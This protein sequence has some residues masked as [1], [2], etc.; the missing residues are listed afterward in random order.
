MSVSATTER[1][2]VSP[3]WATVRK[4][5]TRKVAIAASGF[6]LLI[7]FVSVKA[8]WLAPY[9]Y[10]AQHLD[11]QFGA[12]GVRHVFGTDSKGRDLFSRVLY[13]GRISL[14][15]ALAGTAVSVLIGVSWG[16]VAG[17]AGGRVEWVMMRFVDILYSLP[18]TLLVILLIAVCDQSGFKHRFDGLFGF[19][20]LKAWWARQPF[21]L[22]FLF[23]ALGLVQWLTMAR[24]VRARVTALKFGPSIESA[25]AL[26]AGH[27]W[28]MWRH[29]LPHTIPVVIACATL[30]VPSVMLQE[31][32]ISFLGLG[33]QPPAA[34][35]GTLVAEGVK[36]VN[37]IK[38]AWWVILFPSAVLT[39]SLLAF[40]LLGD[41]F[42]DVW[43]R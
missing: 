27:A 21:N 9:S 18:Y 19:L 42:Q 11:Q 35:W 15:I 33:V 3:A 32:F 43:G 30:T 13:G 8:D 4:L 5:F 14:A 28:I 23:V 37:P 7:L 39:A 24:V 29:I 16:L 20:G 10:S 40:N 22:I 36:T 6:I 2:P 34:S 38:M 26:G 17:Y 41:A 25:R 31:A 12:P 1:A